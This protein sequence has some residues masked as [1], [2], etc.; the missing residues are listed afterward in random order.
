MAPFHRN[1]DLKEEATLCLS[2][3]EC[4]EYMLRGFVHHFQSAVKK[5]VILEWFKLSLVSQHSL[6]C[7]SES[8]D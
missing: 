8:Q 4:D 3:S 2:W 7:F 6:F 1:M 5:V